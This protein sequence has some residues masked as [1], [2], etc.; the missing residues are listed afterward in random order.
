MNASKTQLLFLA[1]GGN[2]A[3]VVVMV[4][5]NIIKPN[6]TIELLGVKYDRKPTTAPHVKAMLTAARHCVSVV[7]WL[8]FSICFLVK[9]DKVPRENLD[10]V[11]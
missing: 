11:S 4:D 7:S 6:V 3:D 10:L 8:A 2:T 9:S 1:N 5:G